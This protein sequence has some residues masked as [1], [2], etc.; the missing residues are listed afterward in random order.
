MTYCLRLRTLAS[1][2]SVL[3]ANVAV[4]RPPEFYEPALPD[5][6][7]GRINGHLKALGDGTQDILGA[8]GMHHAA[9]ELV[10]MMDILELTPMDDQEGMLPE[11][12][13]FW[14]K[15]VGF[16]DEEGSWIFFDRVERPGRA[17]RVYSVERQGRAG[18]VYSVFRD[19]YAWDHL[20]YENFL[21]HADGSCWR[22]SIPTFGETF[23]EIS[24]SDLAYRLDK[25]I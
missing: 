5:Y 23:G 11:S 21:R 2:G 22:I 8:L 18:R 9:I 4:T 7:F 13:G 14:N 16:L 6:E 25:G 12:P 15:P 3:A 20:Y 17:G 19:A 1:K 24:L 10:L